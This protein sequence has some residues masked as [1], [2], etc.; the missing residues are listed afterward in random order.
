MSIVDSAHRAANPDKYPV[1]EEVK[2]LYP[3]YEGIEG[4]IKSTTVHL[5]VYDDTAHVVP[6]TFMSTTP[7][8]Y[9]YRAI[10]TFI[11]HVTN[12]PPTEK[13]RRQKEPLALRTSNIISPE[14]VTSPFALSP[15]G[16]NRPATPLR[17]GEP[18][19]SR[20]K[21]FS[22]VTSSF[23]RG[24]SLFSKASRSH[25]DFIPTE[26][27]CAMEDILAGDPIVYHRG[28]AK[29]PEQQSMIRE[30]V[31]IH[32]AVRPLEGERDLSALQMVPEL[33]G[34]ISERWV[35]RY[36][37]AQERQEKKF[38]AHI[39][40]IAKRRECAIAKLRRGSQSRPPEEAAVS[41]GWS[42]AWALHADER[43]PPSSLVARPD[44]AEA[45][46]LA[47]GGK[48]RLQRADLEK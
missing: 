36:I 19:P 40:H 43:P 15:Q 10:A 20:R 25:S 39:K 4:R 16:E 32:G 14:A 30:R 21:G 27:E 48:R 7:A 1:S 18:S 31:A 33:L 41:S 2:K 46:E 26:D 47:R 28:W 29:S 5:Q 37:A 38:S 22:R 13:L 45:L 9:C 12:M 6:L 17:V 44:T 3:A 24:S 34:A 8:K 11:K 42:L 23:R 35:W